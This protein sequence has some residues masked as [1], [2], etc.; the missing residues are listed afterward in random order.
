MSDRFAAKYSANSYED[1]PTDK[2]AADFGANYFDPKSK[3]TLGDQI[4][5]YLNNNLKATT[6]DK[7]PNYKSLPTTEPTDKPTRT[8]HTTNPVYTTDHP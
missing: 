8:N 5:N 4:Q 1:L 3:L 7:A 2:F 6:P